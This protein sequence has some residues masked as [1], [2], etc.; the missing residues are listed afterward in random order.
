MT[1]SS[2]V[3]TADTARTTIC[4]KKILH[5]VGDKAKQTE[6]VHRHLDGLKQGNFNDQARQG[7]FFEVMKITLI[8]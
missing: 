1:C 7:N 2:A 3:N 6:I 4:K 8:S 5:I